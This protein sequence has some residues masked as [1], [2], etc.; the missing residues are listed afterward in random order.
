MPFLLHQLLSEA[1]P[2]PRPKAPFGGP[3][4]AEGFPVG[5]MACRREVQI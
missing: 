5:V 2:F 1:S 3:I 4:L